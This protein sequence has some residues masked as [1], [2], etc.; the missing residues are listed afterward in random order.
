MRTTTLATIAA[1]HLA[2]ILFRPAP[3]RAD[4][5]AAPAPC[6]VELVDE[7]GAPLPT[8]QH[9][10]RTYV[11]GALGQRYRVRVHNASARRAEVV[12]SV[13]GRDVIDGRPSSWEKRGY[14]VEPWSD[15]II[16]GFRLDEANV[17]AFRFATV[18]RSYASRMGDPRDVGVV[19]VALFLERWAPPRPPISPDPY[20]A[21]RDASR[22]EAHSDGAR[23]GAPAPTEAP[24]AAQAPEPQR[25][26]RSLARRG[27]GTEFGEVHDSRV[28][29]VPFER[30]SA[31]PDAVVALR[32]DDREGL[33]A[34]GI[35]MDRG[36]S[37]ADGDAWLRESADPFRRDR[38]AEPP[39]GWG[40]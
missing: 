17:A 8:F 3:A 26:A 4:A 16:D 32:Y 27:L 11:L 13:D 34:L 33:V 40:R 1:S 31:R 21:P 19:G 25:D 5:L 24:S 29:T 2:V 14:V 12:A 22:P 35:D 6:S 30:A 36:L 7:A 39:P 10:G 20:S 23:S 38:F 9:R 15:V 28:Q 37:S 18:P